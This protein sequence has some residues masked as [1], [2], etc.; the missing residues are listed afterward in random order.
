MVKTLSIKTSARTQ[1]LDITS[2]VRRVVEESGVKDGLCI[3]FVPHTTAG[4]TI[5]ENADPDV[6]SDILKEIN[7]VIPF[8]DDYRHMEGNRQPI[9]SKPVRFLSYHHRFS[10]LF[11]GTWR[12]SISRIDGPRNR[13]VKIKIIEG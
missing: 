4:V 9:S 13:Q 3:V 7:K 5:N 1:L 6:T 10:R 8:S 12:A 11:L 2:Q